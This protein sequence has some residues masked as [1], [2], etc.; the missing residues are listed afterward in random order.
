MTGLPRTTAGAAIV[1]PR[2]PIAT[3]I[4]PIDVSIAAFL[5]GFRRTAIIF[6]AA[7]SRQIAF[8]ARATVFVAAT[9]RHAISAKNFAI[10]VFGAVTIFQTFGRSGA[11]KKAR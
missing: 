7:P 1:K 11:V 9:D 3:T 8:F 6:L 10:R 4:H 5:T 2:P